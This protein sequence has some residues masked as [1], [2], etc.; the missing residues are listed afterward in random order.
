VRVGVGSAVAVVVG[1]GVGAVVDTD[2]RFGV[3]RTLTAAEVKVGI[4]G[5]SGE[6]SEWS[7][8]IGGAAGGVGGGISCVVDRWSRRWHQ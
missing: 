4:G 7:A 6:S 1:F 3:G 2:G 5:W 8:G